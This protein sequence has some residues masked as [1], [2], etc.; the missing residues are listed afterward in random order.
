MAFFVV[1]NLIYKNFIIKMIKL[2]TLFGALLSAFIIYAQTQVCNYNSTLNLQEQALKDLQKEIGV[3][4]KMTV[5]FNKQLDCIDVE[6]KFVDENSLYNQIQK[7]IKVTI[8][9]VNKDVLEKNP[10][11]KTVSIEGKSDEETLNIL[12]NIYKDLVNKKDKILNSNRPTKEKE[13]K[14]LMK[15]YEELLND[16][17]NQN[18]IQIAFFKATIDVFKFNFFVLF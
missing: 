6:K 13:V 2:I 14:D 16:Q 5:K 17:I 10:K 11:V 15:A 9:A 1:F 4:G 18:Y 7:L 12:K 3:S 8:V